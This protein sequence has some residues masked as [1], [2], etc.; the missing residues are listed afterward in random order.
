[1]AKVK[2]EDSSNKVYGA[3]K[4]MIADY[5]FQPGVRLKIE[6]LA[7]E[8]G[9]TRTSVSEAIRR[10]EQEGL[11]KNMPNRGIIM[12]EMTLEKSFEL[13]QVRAAL[14]TLVGKLA[15]EN[16]D[17]R[18]VTK[19]A[20]CLEE[21]LEVVKKGDLIRY[22]QLDFDFHS[23]IYE[24]TRNSFLEELLDS[25]KAKMRP[26]DIHLKPILTQLY[27]DHAKIFEAL[28]SKNP[29]AAE[30]AFARHNEKIINRIKEQIVADLAF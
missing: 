16:I 8:L 28:R 13:F 22:S 17:D 2:R 21:Q 25:I 26:F 9:A 29:E 19:M 30:K 1:M 10:L 23:M 5:R 12:V 14:E 24:M 3:L 15:A 20:K 4:G 18:T 27:Q 11:V 6:D 7:K